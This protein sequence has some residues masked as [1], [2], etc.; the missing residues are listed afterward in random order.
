MKA[1]RGKDE[2]LTLRA[3]PMTRDCVADIR[4]IIVRARRSV[5]RHVNTTMTLAYW[6]IGRRI[7]VEE[8]KGKRRATYG[9]HLLQ[10]ISRELTADFGNGFGE[11]QLRNCRLFFRAFPTEAEIRYTLCIKLSWSHLRE[12]MRVADPKARAYYLIPPLLVNDKYE[13][14]RTSRPP[15]LSVVRRD[16][17]IRRPTNFKN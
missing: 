9:E 3:M 8:Q 6:L 4:E 14:I 15:R 12:I 7:V 1:E 2:A 17:H 13:I 16:A 5:V 11:P 10:R